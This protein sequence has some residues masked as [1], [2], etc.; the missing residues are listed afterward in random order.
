MGGSFA[1]DFAFIYPFSK[2]LQIYLIPVYTYK[3]I[4][5]FDVTI[6]PPFQPRMSFLTPREAPAYS[7]T[8]VAIT[9]WPSFRPR[10]SF[11]IPQAT[12]T[13]IRILFT[14]LTNCNRSV[15]ERYLLQPGLSPSQSYLVR[16]ATAQ[17]FASELH[18]EHCSL[19]SEK[20]NL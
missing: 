2:V 5:W 14:C 4:K 7:Q 11:L 8:G 6:W 15:I 12:F 19:R 17:R 18:Q 1:S 3:T 16:G 20:R 13:G 10:M 9:I